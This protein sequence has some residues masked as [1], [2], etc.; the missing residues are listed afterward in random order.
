MRGD[1]RAQDWGLLCGGF[2]QQDLHVAALLIEGIRNVADAAMD[3]RTWL[4]G[5]WPE[6]CCPAILAA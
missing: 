5:L 2:P 1:A 6:T 3:Q 4:D